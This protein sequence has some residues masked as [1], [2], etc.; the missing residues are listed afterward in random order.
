M[1]SILKQY[2]NVTLPKMD[3]DSDV[4]IVRYWE[5]SVSYKWWDI[6][7][8]FPTVEAVRE[9]IRYIRLLDEK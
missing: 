2:F 6:F 1:K 8:L 4:A 7:K 5:H 9:R 3:S